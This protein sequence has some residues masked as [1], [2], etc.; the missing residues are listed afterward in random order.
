MFKKYEPILFS[1][2]EQAKKI[3]FNILRP[4]HSA[5]SGHI[6]G[7]LPVADILAALYFHYMKTRPND[8]EWPHIDRFNFIKRHANAT[9]GAVLV[10]AGHI[11]QGILKQFYG[12]ESLF[13]MHPDIR[14]V[15]VEI[16]TGGLGHKLSIG[17]G[18]SNC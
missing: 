5:S 12:F 9:I 4:L 11:N 13:R 17:V 15:G 8:P 14:L 10:Q 16:S 6:G 3:G 2:Q 18:W 7:S 1:V